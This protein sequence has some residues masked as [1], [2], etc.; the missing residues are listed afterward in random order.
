MPIWT[1]SKGLMLRLLR[2]ANAP[3]QM[4]TAARILHC[5]HC[6]LMARRTGAVRP[7][8]VSRSKDIGH[9]IAIDACHW[10]RNR[11][12]REAII[13]NIIDKVSRFH[14]ALVL[15]KGEPSE[16]GNLT[17]MTTSKLSE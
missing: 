10:K 14:V 16:L 3:L 15:K 2:D 11:D 13:V 7:V 5:P 4:L 8:Q 6:D 12:G 1:S 9:T 17:A